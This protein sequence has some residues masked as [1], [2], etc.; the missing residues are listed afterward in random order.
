MK[1]FNRALLYLLCALI[2]AIPLAYSSVRGSVDPYLV[3]IV[4]SAVLYQSASHV[5][6]E[7]TQFGYVPGLGILLIVLAKVSG[8]DPEFTMY[9]PIAGGLLILTSVVLARRFTRSTPLA[10]AVALV[11]GYRW[12]PSDLSTVW[13][14]AFGFTLYFLFATM[15][16]KMETA[17]QSRYVVVLWILF[18]GI[19]MF[20]YT[21]ELWVI[22]FVGVATLLAYLRQGQKS[23]LTTSLLTAIIVTFF[24][25]T[26]IIYT[27]FIPGL[28]TGAN[29]FG[30]GL[31]A[32]VSSLFRAGPAVPY[33][34]VPPPTPL[35]VLL[36]QVVWYLAL[37]LPPGLVLGQRI[38]KS[39]KSRNIRTLFGVPPGIAG[40]VSVWPFDAVAYAVLGALPVGLFRYSTLSGTLLT[41]PALEELT[42][43][44][45]AR[46]TGTIRLSASRLMAVALVVVSMVL[47]ASAT[48][49]VLTLTSLSKYADTR[50]GANWLLSNQ[51]GV[52]SVYSDHMTQSQFAIAA[53]RLG[54]YFGTPDL[55]NVTSY[56]ALLGIGSYASNRSYFGNRYVVVNLELAKFKTTSGHWID[57]E[58]LQ[59]HLSQIDA[60]PGLS[61]IY[62]DGNLWI[63][64]GT[65]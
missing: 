15:Y 37:F 52:Q 57:F 49:Q 12:L 42:S 51:P 61:R 46:S 22:A 16:L 6:I 45:I 44:R 11:I 60:N 54:L 5:P 40:F 14:H 34:W 59:P 47:F 41:M 36:L 38:I 58:A 64:Q 55:Y 24:G 23:K 17:R 1:P 20:S 13:P 3:G 29:E 21:T 2:A 32:L 65:G 48:S 9:L 27:G 63:M 26:K 35:I 39:S 19:H 33:G 10:L 25:F 62:D 43:K 56:E 18:L 53:A 8:L 31:Q 30:F 4:S 7:A 28:Q 50:P